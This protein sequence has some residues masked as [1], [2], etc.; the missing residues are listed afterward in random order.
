[1]N[2]ETLERLMIDRAL[3][4]LPADVEELL[5]AYLESRTDSSEQAR[6]LEVLVATARRA[7]TG[8]LDHIVTPPVFIQSGRGEGLRLLT[9]AGRVASLVAALLLGIGV[10]LLGPGRTESVR[11]STPVASVPT[12]SGALASP[13][14]HARAASASAGPAEETDAFWSARRLV[15]AAAR[16]PGSTTNRVPWGFPSSLLEKGQP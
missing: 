7:L 5:G 8:D 15:A 16:P 6:E 12:P 10:G 4:C 11:P 14:W 9:F 13:S 2:G 1:M 3:G